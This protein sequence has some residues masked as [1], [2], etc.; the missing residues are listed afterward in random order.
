[1]KIS[2]GC[3]SCSLPETQ[4]FYDYAIVWPPQGHLMKKIVSFLADTN[5]TFDS[6][7]TDGFVII[8][9]ANIDYF[10]EQLSSTL[11]SL[12]AADT[13]VLL[14]NTKAPTLGAFKDVVSLT[15][16]VDRMNNRWLIS[17]LEEERY[18]SYAQPI[19]SA[20]GTWDT[21]AHE[22]LIR[23]LSEEGELIYPDTLF[24]AAKDP[25]LLFNLDRAARINAVKT[26][27]WMKND[28]DIFI[29]FL[30][31]SV[32]D[33]KVCLQTTIAAVKEYD[34][35]PDRIV[36]EIVESHQ[37]DDIEHLRE[38]VNFYRS[39]GFRVALDDFGTGF[40]NLDMY[41]AL[42]PDFVKLDKSLT[43]NLTDDDPR[44][45]MVKGIVRTAHSSKINV[46]AEGIES[47]T[48]ARVVSD[49][50]VDRM[51]GYFFGR[52]GPVEERVVS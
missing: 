36:I 40:N 42:D 38:I 30:P 20:E 2:T 47:A 10:I 43:M 32:Y 4:D 44:L 6:N 50:G 34:V 48:N 28:G 33:P 49:C 14:S 22:F 18:V 46:I 12:E 41:I 8:E 52:P 15:T 9:P 39:V 21:V 45:S 27:S 1:M 16:M 17:M 13:R 37:I 19:V 25:Q 11:T 29:N 3:Q 5:V 35:S 51:Q 31:G 7:P 24:G 26:A 23:G